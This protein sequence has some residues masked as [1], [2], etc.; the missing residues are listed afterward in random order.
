MIK[1][2]GFN[3]CKNCNVALETIETEI[4]NANTHKQ[5]QI[6]IQ[7]SIENEVRLCL[8]LAL[9]LFKFQIVF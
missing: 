9:C 4:S 8:D 5:K 1:V 2:F 7:T 3:R 6:D